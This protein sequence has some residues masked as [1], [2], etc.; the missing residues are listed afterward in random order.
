[1]SH[2]H[3]HGHGHDDHHG[4]HAEPEAE[5]PREP[6]PFLQLLIPLA[7]V[8]L[9]ILAM[10]S[11]SR[12]AG[13]AEGAG[14]PAVEIKRAGEAN[15]WDVTIGGKPFTSYVFNDQLFFDKPV[16]WP[17]LSP[18]GATLNRNF[19]M[20]KGVK[21]EA[22][23]HPHHQALW[24][25]YG[26]VNGIDFWNIQKGGRRIRH[27][28][29]EIDGAVLKTTLEWID[30]A[31]T[32]LLEEQK[33]VTFGGGD[34][35]FWMDHDIVLTAKSE[36]VIGDSKEGAFAIRV[37]RGL[38]EIKNG[39]GRYLNAE[40]LET[41]KE[42]WGKTSPWVALRG[43]APGAAGETPVTLAIFS[44]PS[45]VNHPPYW[46]ARDYGLFAANPF[47]RKSYDKAAEPR[48]IKLAP[49]ES[50][51]ARFRFLA[52]EGTP[53]KARLDADYADFSK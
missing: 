29:A 31:G 48:E 30:K 10:I 42:V 35:V 17:V 4:S 22:L 41:S 51:H 20:V 47:G 53:E 43:T 25:N 8:V 7:G 1:M 14:S 21:G 28:A 26:S 24:F 33:N 50:V 39:T 3:G 18:S 34:G 5:A 19:P 12:K 2:D 27:K 52:Y 36:T 23:D 38:E 9:V 16:F 44:H 37:A 32:V 46:H 15:Q 49:G 45:T 40:G 6:I 13:G 11:L